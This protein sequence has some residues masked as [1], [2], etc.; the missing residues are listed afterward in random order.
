MQIAACPIISAGK[1][2]ETV[3]Q[4][5]RTW[6]QCSGLE[7]IESIASRDAECAITRTTHRAAAAIVAAGAVSGDTPGSV[8]TSCAQMTRPTARLAMSYAR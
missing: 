4:P 3:R 6:S 5:A 7:R 2:Q 8:M 1:G